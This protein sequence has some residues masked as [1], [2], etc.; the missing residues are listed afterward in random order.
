[1]DVLYGVII[2]ILKTWI[3]QYFINID[4]INSGK[5]KTVSNIYLKEK[6]KIK[7]NKNKIDFVG[8]YNFLDHLEN[9]L[10]LFNKDLKNVEILA[11][12]CEDIDLSKK[13]D[14]QHFSSWSHKSLLFLS[15]KLDIPLL[16]NHLRLSNS[17]YKL[18]LLKKLKNE[19]TTNYRFFG[20]Q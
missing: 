2:I 13:I 11:I 7:L 4:E 14:C 10:K 5:Q 16:I 12:I 17:I 9:P 6:I 15:K 3:K 20:I 18:Y 19:R 8:I 1:M